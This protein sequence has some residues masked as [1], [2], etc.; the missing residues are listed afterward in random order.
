M[1]FVEQ[2]SF[3]GEQFMSATEKQLILSAWITFLRHGCRLEHFSERLYHHLSLHCSFIAHFNRHG[4]YEFYFAT[5]SERTHRFLDQF[6]PS[7]PGIA[8][9]LGEMYWLMDRA[10]GSDLNHAMREAAGA[11]TAK[12]R[13]QFSEAEKQSDLTLA[14]LLAA[15]YGKRLSEC[16]VSPQPE[17]NSWISADAA[18][19]E[20]SSAEQLSMF[21]PAD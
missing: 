21:T 1:S 2:F 7:K 19:N 4:F 3:Q 17:G 9:E 16:H 20:N 12:L 14:S 8:A 11:Y 5:P 10:T 15:K 6:D 18:H 13:H